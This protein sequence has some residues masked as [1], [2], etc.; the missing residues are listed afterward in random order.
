MKELFLNGYLIHSIICRM[1]QSF[2]H[3]EL[4]KFFENG[5]SS[6]I[7]DQHF[8]RLQLVLFK[9]DTAETIK[10]LNFPGSNLHTLSGKMQDFW[11][12]QVSGNWRVIFRFEEGNVFDVDYV[13]YH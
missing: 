5:K 1:I 3:R 13:D 12:I 7:N 8:K 4:K 6:K 11:S 10:D 9:L 2:R